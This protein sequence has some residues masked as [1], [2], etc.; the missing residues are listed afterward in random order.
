MA[1]EPRRGLSPKVSVAL[2]L[3]A[4]SMAPGEAAALAGISRKQLERARGSQAGK[5]FL[6]DQRDKYLEELR[7]ARVVLQCQHDA[8]VFGR[9]TR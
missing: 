1:W 3:F 4:T 2:T 8:K 6:Q 5:Q 9:K 7:R